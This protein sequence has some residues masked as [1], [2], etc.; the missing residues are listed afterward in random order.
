MVL[1]LF[2]PEKDYVFSNTQVYCTFSAKGEINQKIGQIILLRDD[3]H[4]KCQYRRI[5]LPAHISVTS[6]MG[7]LVKDDRCLVLRFSGQ[8]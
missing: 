8:P 4:Q 6:K 3:S 7:C 5:F 1:D 2:L